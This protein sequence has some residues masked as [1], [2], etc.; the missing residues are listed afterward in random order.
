MSSSSVEQLTAEFERTL[1]IHWRLPGDLRDETE[2]LLSGLN[3]CQMLG[4]R[5]RQQALLSLANWKFRFNAAGF[6]A[7]LS[8]AAQDGVF[9]NYHD[10]CRLLGFFDA[11]DTDS[12]HAWLSE[13]L[14]AGNEELALAFRPIE[15]TETLARLHTELADEEKRE[16]ILRSLFGGFVFRSFPCRPLHEFFNPQCRDGYEDRFHAHLSRFYPE[17]VARETALVAMAVDV[18][19]MAALHPAAVFSEHIFHSIRAAHERLA[20]HCY[21]AIWL[22]GGDASSY[23]PLWRLCS[24]ITL[25]AE[26][27]RETSLQTGY[28]HPSKIRAQT[29]AHIPL[30]DTERARFDLANEG[31]Y[32]K[33]CFV[34]PQTEPPDG[35][36]DTP[37]DLLLLFEKNE[38]DETLIPCPACRSIQ[39][40]GNSYPVLG[41]RSW[42]CQNPLCPERSKYDRGNRYSL[43]SLLR[44]EA[45]EAPENRIPSASLRRWKRDIVS[46]TTGAEI[47]EMLTR[48]YTFAGD[49]VRLWDW[50]EDAA[51]RCGRK[52]IAER[53]PTPPPASKIAD[54]FF[55][56]AFFHRFRVERPRAHIPAASEDLSSTPTLSFLHGEAFETL[57]TLPEESIDGAVTSPPYY[58]AK[59]Y[60]S[61]PNIYCYLHDMRSIAQE[62]FR[63][64]RP[65]AAFLFNIFDYFDNE[66][67]M[68]FSAM[69]KKRM[70]LGAYTVRLFEELGFELRGNA[71]WD[72]GEIEGKRNFN[73]GNH[74]PYYQ[75]PFNCWEHIFVFCKPGGSHGPRFPT[76]LKAR[77]VFKMVNGENVLGHSAPF[78]PEIPELLLARMTSGENVLDPFAGSFTTCRAAHRHGLRA[79]GI[80]Y[81]R[82]YCSLGLRLLREETKQLEMFALT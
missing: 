60:S 24:D 57:Q 40:R 36:S 73:Q 49:A 65:G 53:A 43:Q 54:T 63:V 52:V 75:A 80:E 42:E 41:V 39:V 77:P 33:D 67:N 58:N 10:K 56:S 16:G 15:P 7:F 61:W 59:S 78:P 17:A 29:L 5:Q 70:I 26:K 71:V 9:F 82:D 27:F 66:N 55:G 44:Q 48:H 22:R 12:F 79:I 72:K 11:G 68:V 45:I 3:G 14:A 46:G 8:Q 13:T 6:A 51:V 30:L 1:G 25:Y 21:L 74:S 35:E 37:C 76:I 20:N 62:I 28:F 38:R 47:L 64:L 69:G 50:P 4:E 23:A 19:R 34:L 32:F 18:T 2:K 31:L 81:H